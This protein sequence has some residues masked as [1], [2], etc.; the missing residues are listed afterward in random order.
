MIK[1]AT[2]MHKDE[3]HLR[4]TTIGYQQTAIQYSHTD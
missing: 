2:D 1:S 3:L 4:Q